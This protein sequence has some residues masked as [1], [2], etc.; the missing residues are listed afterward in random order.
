MSQIIRIQ[1]NNQLG[2]ENL[3]AQSWS[4]WIWKDCNQSWKFLSEC[5]NLS[6]RESINSEGDDSIDAWRLEENGGCERRKCWRVRTQKLFNQDEKSIQLRVFSVVESLA[7]QIRSLFVRK[8]EWNFISSDGYGRQK[9][10]CRFNARWQL[11][12][13]GGNQ[14][15]G[16]NKLEHLLIGKY[17][18][19]LRWNS[20][21]N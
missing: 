2:V 5:F 18:R 15:W 12:C 1:N 21:E 4:W 19:F 20:R 17:F 10:S 16:D 6:V 7:E 11:S 9:I 14:K 13:N 3:C 8:C